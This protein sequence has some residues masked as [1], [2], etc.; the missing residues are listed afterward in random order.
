MYVYFKSYHFKIIKDPR[1]N[2]V[3]PLFFFL[4]KKNERPERHEMFKSP[5]ILCPEI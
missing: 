1:Y 5:G 3:Q 2:L 4:M